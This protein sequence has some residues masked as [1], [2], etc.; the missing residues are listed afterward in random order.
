[1]V[2]ASGLLPVKL[3]NVPD[4]IRRPV[5]RAIATVSTAAADIIRGKIKVTAPAKDIKARVV[6]ETNTDG[7]VTFFALAIPRGFVIDFK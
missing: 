1:M 2:N 7:S 5:R 3:V 6:E 4:G